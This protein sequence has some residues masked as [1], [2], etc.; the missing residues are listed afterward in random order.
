MNDD[1]AVEVNI[2]VD[3]DCE[4]QWGTSDPCVVAHNSDEVAVY[5]NRR[6]QIVIRRE[7]DWNETDDAVIIV[8]RESARSI[9]YALLR[10]AKEWEEAMVRQAQ[11]M[12][13]G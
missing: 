6:G 13:E 5:A 12:K 3:D 1:A 10:I 7:A 2:C 4:P 8:N 11:P 9:G